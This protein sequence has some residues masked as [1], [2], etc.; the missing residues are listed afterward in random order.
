MNNFTSCVW[1]Y[2]ECIRCIVFVSNSNEISRR[3]RSRQETCV[4][5]TSWKFNYHQIVLGCWCAY[6]K[7]LFTEVCVRVSSFFFGF[8]SVVF[9]FTRANIFTVAR[10]RYVCVC[11]H[12]RK[13]GKSFVVYGQTSKTSFL[14][15]E[16]GQVCE[17]AR[18]KGVDRKSETSHIVC[19][20][21]KFGSQNIKIPKWVP[22]DLFA[23]LCLVVFVFFFFYRLLPFTPSFMYTTVKQAK[24]ALLKVSWTHTH[25]KDEKKENR[26]PF[27]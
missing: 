24:F 17:S 6:F 2:S 1:A 20:W 3:N 21:V 12:V 10:V 26:T 19:N 8:S 16:C 18:Q 25:T 13:N 14:H 5:A 23:K 11:V 9:L 7:Y 4:H 22:F 27:T 15:I